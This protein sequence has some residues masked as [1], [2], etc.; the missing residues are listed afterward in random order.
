MDDH[1]IPLVYLLNTDVGSDKALQASGF[2]AHRYKLNGYVVQEQSYLAKSI[3]YQH[4][5]PDNIHEAE[6]IVIDT[7]LSNF[8]HGAGRTSSVSVYFEHTPSYVDLL[9]IDMSVISN[10]IFSTKKKQAVVVFCSSNTDMFYAIESGPTRNPRQIRYSTYDFND[11]YLGVIDR[12]GN[13]FKKPDNVIAKDLTDLIF[14]YSRGSNYNVVFNGVNGQDLILAENEGGEV[15]SFIRVIK[16]KTFI[17]LPVIN[18]KTE[19]L[20]ELFS[21]VLPDIPFFEDYFPNNGSFQWINS[22]LYLSY[23][24][25]TKSN[26]IEELKSEYE[27][28]NLKLQSELSD[29]AN[30]DENIKT[31]ALLT[32]TDDELVFSVKWFLNYIGFENV[33]VPDENVNEENG[34]VFEED[35]NIETPSI[36]YLFEVKGIGGTSSDDQCAQ[37]SKIVY[38]RE[39]ANPDHNYKGVYI[40]NHQR[41]KNPKERKNPPFFEQQELDAAIA[42]RGMTYTY[43]L[44]Q[45]Y[46]MIE[47]GILDKADVREAFNQRGLID[48]HKSFKPL[49]CDHTFREIN[50]YSFDLTSTPGTTISE[51]DRVVV[52]D[53]DNHWHLL[54]IVGIQVN[55]KPIEEATSDSGAS[56]G[57]KVDRLV[58]GAREFFLLKK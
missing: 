3:A 7:T 16:E 5:I 45:V 40:V 37:I 30:K 47:S 1:N 21:S 2:N 24:E 13:R 55:K 23:E 4:R 15:L 50:V 22:E 56:A 41:Q 20:N 26:E 12:T 28:N 6:I 36:T 46:H 31:K 51:K 14:K 48:F 42:R 33:I 39:E 34:E 53:D 52:K 27:K 57:V 35:L 8:S 18:N 29:L 25:K 19:F 43:E 54:S 11:S 9:P 17:F 38:R 58:P 49:T 10:G 32:A 44:F